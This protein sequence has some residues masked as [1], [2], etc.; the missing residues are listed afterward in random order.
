MSTDIQ[1]TI[2]Q[3]LETVGHESL[4]AVE[5]AAAWLVGKV[6]M[7]GES[8]QTLEKSSPLF[9]EA[10][11]AGVT[12]AEAHGVPV[13]EVEDVFVAVMTAAKTLAAGLSQTAPSAAA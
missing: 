3:K 9:A 13:V 1:P 2:I 11:T 10:W 12:A 7:C 8:L 5:H 4:D 6:A